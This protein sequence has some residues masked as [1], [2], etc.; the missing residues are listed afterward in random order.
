MA[1]ASKFGGRFQVLVSWPLEVIYCLNSAYGVS[2][3]PVS[4]FLDEIPAE[5][6]RQVKLKYLK[7]FKI[8]FS[9]FISF[10]VKKENPEFYQGHNSLT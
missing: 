10:S 3:P 8:Q 2:L 7:N 1:A 5:K 4:V 9:I 6:K